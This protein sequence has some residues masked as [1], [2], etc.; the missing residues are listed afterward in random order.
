V[1]PKAASGC[2]VTVHS[3]AQN[4]ELTYLD[5]LLLN[6]KGFERL[7]ERKYEE[8]SQLFGEALRHNSHESS[9]N[10]NLGLAYYKLGGYEEALE[11]VEKA[12][13]HNSWS[14]AGLM[15]LGDILV[16]LNRPCQAR[17]AYIEALYQ[18]RDDK[19]RSE[20][21]AKLLALPPL[22]QYSR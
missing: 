10:N 17:D 20:I 13:E 12:F 4:E 18:A 1:C 5:S 11:C 16:K 14:L 3:P 6:E 22:P 7:E 9:I 2:A 8:A 15:N 21:T 19:T